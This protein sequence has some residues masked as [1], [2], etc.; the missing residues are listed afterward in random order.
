MTEFRVREMTPADVTTAAEMLDA[1][2]REFDTPTPGPA[3]LARRLPRLTADG[4]LTVLLS[5]EPAVGVAVVSLR[6]NVWSDGPVALL[7]EL[8]VRP[9]HRNRRHG[10]ALL[11]AAC[12]LARTHGAE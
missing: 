2:N 7:D 4:R 11:E 6:P 8:Y 3:V 9:E 1:F 5:G 10:H 12:D